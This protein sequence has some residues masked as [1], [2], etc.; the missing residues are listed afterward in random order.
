[1]DEVAPQRFFFVHIMKTGGATFRQHVYANF[2]EGEVYPVPKVEDMDRAWLVDYVLG[3][4]EERRARFRAY[5]GHFPF[6]VTELLPEDFVTMTMVRHPVARTISYLKHCK[7]YHEHH[8]DLS[9]DAIYQ[10]Q[11]H[12]DCFIHN[13]QTKI[14][15]M[16]LGDRLESY[17]DRIDVDESR[18]DQVHNRRVSRE[19]KWVATPELQ[20]R[21]AED[22]AID[23]AFYEHAVRVY[24]HRPRS[25][26]VP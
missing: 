23:M 20:A 11:F 26:A 25:R 17:M 3:L 22:N 16:K 18:L 13:H 4:P 7:R 21:I 14:F 9:L 15:S 8:R 12:F 19:K 1:M 5:T 10:D 2:A 24:E 6:V